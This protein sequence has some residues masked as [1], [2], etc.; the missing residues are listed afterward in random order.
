MKLK[1]TYHQDERVWVKIRPQTRD[2]FKIKATELG[3]PSMIK[4]LEDI[5][6]IP[7]PKLKEII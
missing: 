6:K 2:N 4:L 5:S 1:V 3:Y 7:S